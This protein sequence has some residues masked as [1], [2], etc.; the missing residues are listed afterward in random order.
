MGSHGPLAHRDLWERIWCSWQLLGDSVSVQWVPSH[1]GVQG[2]EQADHCAQ[3][4]QQGA[5]AALP[6]ARE[7]KSVLEAWQELGPEEML[8]RDESGMAALDMDGGGSGSHSS[9]DGTNETIMSEDSDSDSDYEVLESPRK[10][11]CA[12]RGP[13]GRSS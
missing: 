10:R 11:Q 8:E 5:T 7:A 12:N 4:G 3:Q 9:S 6:I 2:N 13:R 1:V